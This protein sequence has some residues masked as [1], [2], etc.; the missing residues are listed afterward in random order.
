[1]HRSSWQRTGLAPP[2]W[3]AL[4]I[5]IALLACKRGGSQKRYWTSGCIPPGNEGEVVLGGD[6]TVR[7]DL[8]S[9]QVKSRK[10]EYKSDLGC[11]PNGSVVEAG[12]DPETMGSTRTGRVVS[13]WT[14][15]HESS[16]R[17]DK[18][19]IRQQSGSRLEVELKTDHFPDIGPPAPRFLDVHPVG[20]VG[21]SSAVV[22]ASYVPTQASRSSVTS[23]PFALYAFDV[24][25]GASTRWSAVF[26]SD[27][28]VHQ[29]WAKRY[30]IAR[31]GSAA[32]GVFGWEHHI[33]SA[34]LT[35]EGTVSFRH[36]HEDVRDAE[37]AAV[38]M[39]GTRA[40]VG[41]T[42]KDGA[43]SYVDLLDMTNGQRVLRWPSTPLDGRVAFLRFLQDGSL[44]AATSR[45]TVARI[46]PQGKAV[47]KTTL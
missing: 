24:T 31:D 1:M 21:E 11:F 45:R 39:D 2:A 41:L 46:S 17:W 43:S 19:I 9:G 37:R 28:T 23:R 13:F 4:L 20:I 27:N 25:S 40:A 36:A 15:P 18:L 10:V 44:I 30:A 22:A 35:K 6:E 42:L 29:H 5:A 47:W 34:G 32:L 12:R 33:V 8:A 7:L 14:D 26:P 38:S 3:A 16:N